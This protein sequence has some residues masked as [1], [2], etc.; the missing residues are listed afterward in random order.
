[1]ATNSKK[2]AQDARQAELDK[3]LK[4]IK[5]EFGTGAIMR[6]GE[7][8]NSNVEAISTGILSLDI[9]LG[10]GGFP[11]G[12][13]VEIFGAESSG[14]TTIALQAVAELQKNGGTAAY[15]DAENAMDPEY[16][17]ALGVNIDDLLLSQPG[18]GEEGLQIADALIG[19]GAIDLVVVDSVAALVPKSEIEGDIGDSHVGLQARL[20]SQA[21][22]K[23]T[24]NINKTKTVVIFINQLREKVGVMFGNPETTPGGRALKFYSSVRLRVSGSKQSKEGQ[25]VVGKETKIKVAKNKVAPPFKTVDTL[26]SFGHGIEPVADMVNLAVDKDIINKS[27]SW[28]SYGEERLGQGLNK[29]VANLKEKPELVDELTHKVRVAYGIEKED[30]EA[31]KDAVKDNAKETATTNTSTKSEETDLDV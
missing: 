24:A 10:I 21:L 1:M 30:P 26:M 22:R 20:M 2:S 5:K 18:T 28:Y 12:R 3:A 13:V 6:M 19:S 9:A 14:K 27:G 4:Q 16:A 8:P 11:R 31:E 17:K 15:I 29:T 25:E 7:T 23:L